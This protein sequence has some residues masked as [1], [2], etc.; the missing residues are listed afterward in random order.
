MKVWRVENEA[1]LGPYA[2]YGS[3][4]LAFEESMRKL[5]VQH[6]LSSRHPLARTRRDFPGGG[7]YGFSS[8]SDL[9]NWFDYFGEHGYDILRELGFA[10]QVYEVPCDEV[11]VWPR[12][13]IFDDT[14]A[15]WVREE[16]FSVCTRTTKVG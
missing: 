5:D 2:N 7:H 11:D 4:M 1:M 8:R 16:E 15:H 9:D 3:T 6:D 13:V 10:I 12:Q 14:N